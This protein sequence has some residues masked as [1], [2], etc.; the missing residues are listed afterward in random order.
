MEYPKSESIIILFYL[1][2]L[3]IIDPD[4]IMNRGFIQKIRNEI[5]K[6]YDFIGF[7]IVPEYIES[8]TK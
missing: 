3:F 4:S 5:E 1:F 8:F 6:G 2:Y 7:E